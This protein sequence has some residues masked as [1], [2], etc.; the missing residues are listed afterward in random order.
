MPVKTGIHIFPNSSILGRLFA[1]GPHLACFEP[2]SMN[3]IQ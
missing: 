2:L 1:E 3:G